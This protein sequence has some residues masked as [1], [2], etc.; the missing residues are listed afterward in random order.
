MKNLIGAEQ[1]I[2]ETYKAVSII[3]RK[4]CARFLVFFIASEGTLKEVKDLQSI[5]LSLHFKTRTLKQFD[6]F[7][8]S[9]EC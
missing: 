7:V 1:N 6:Y 9:T 2:S 8:W 3:S 4:Y 5:F